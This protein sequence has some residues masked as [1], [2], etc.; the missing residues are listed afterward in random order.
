MK[1]AIY[2]RVST[3]NSDQDLTMQTR[4]LVEY[5]E[6]RAWKVVDEYVDVG[7]SVAKEKRPELDPMMAELTVAASM[8]LWAGNST[9]LPARY[10]I[11]SEP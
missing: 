6:R 1:A 4:E 5:C 7:I 2:A 10:L 3:A 9:A 11:C 8:R